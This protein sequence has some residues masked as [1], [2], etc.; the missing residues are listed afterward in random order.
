MVSGRCIEPISAPKKALSF[1]R[2]SR[3]MTA[4]ADRPESKAEKKASL[5]WPMAEI[6]PRPVMMLLFLYM[7]GKKYQEQ[8]YVSIFYFINY[9]CNKEAN[10]GHYLLYMVDDRKGRF[11]KGDGISPRSSLSFWL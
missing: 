2:P 3:C 7:M 9:G 4:N 5:P 6:I 11:G 8:E 1:W 10:R